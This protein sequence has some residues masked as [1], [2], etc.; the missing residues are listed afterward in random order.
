ML[1]R[2]EAILNPW[3]NRLNKLGISV[4]PK[5]TEFPSFYEAW[6]ASFPLE[7]VQKVN[8][9]TGSRLF[10]RANFETKEKIDETFKHIRLSTENNRVQV[11]FNIKAV[12]PDNADNAV[13]PAWRQNILFAQ[14]A[15]R[16]PV[17]GTAEETVAIR[18]AFQAGDMQRW[19][20]ISPGAGSYLN[21]ADRF[22]PNF[23][24]AFWGRNY[25]RLLKIKAKLDPWDV[26]YA[27]TAVGS[28]RW[29]LDSPGGLLNENGK[30]CRVGK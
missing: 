17:N 4:D 27:T 2:S 10:P 30:L 5:I 26:F 14:Q 18:K 1:F 13:H 28:E 24:E 12:D 3:L 6:N 25:P 15:V 19:R 20:N 22:E 16:W 8:A 29:K 21:E 9:T 11:H 7:V 23:G